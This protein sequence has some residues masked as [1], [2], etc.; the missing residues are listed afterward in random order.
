[1]DTRFRFP[2]EPYG[3]SRGAKPK[4]GPPKF[5]DAVF[6]VAAEGLTIAI[7]LSD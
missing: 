3:F 1:M 4:M 2:R 7:T 6:E 5:E